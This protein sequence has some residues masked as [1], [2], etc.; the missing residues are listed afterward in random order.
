[1]ISI[2]KANQSVVVFLNLPVEFIEI[3]ELVKDDAVIGYG[4]INQDVRN[5]ITI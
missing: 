4:V 2:R 5:M 3:Y 1:M